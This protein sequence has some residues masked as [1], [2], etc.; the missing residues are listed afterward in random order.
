MTST[1]ATPE[2]ETT[3]YLKRTFKASREQV[4]HAWTKPE[5]MKEWFAA[6]EEM[7]GTFAEA[8]LRVGGKFRMGMRHIPTG[9]Q[10]VGTGIYKVVQ[11]PERLVFTWLWE[12]GDKPGD[13]QI[14]IELR[15]VNRETEMY[16]KHEFFPDKKSRDGHE[17]G[18]NA[19]FQ[20]LERVVQL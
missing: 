16:F 17:T 9:K 20:N 2:T 8:D 7:V 5:M 1:T 12:E 11:F 13:M 14:T 18:W 6:G 4:F 15:D 10:H 19:C 3:L